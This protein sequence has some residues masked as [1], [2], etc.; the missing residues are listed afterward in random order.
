DVD[1]GNIIPDNV[2]TVNFIGEIVMSFLFLLCFGA[3]V[4][5][6]VGRIIRV[7]L[8]LRDCMRYGMGASFLFTGVDHF[9]NDT[10]RY[11]PMIPEALADHALA[12]VY[13]TGAAELAGAIALL[14]PVSAYRRLG[15][16]NL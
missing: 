11:V 16:P 14:I 6:A 12:W 10:V 9:V 4:A 15:L 7:R 8:T 13:L 2:S 3:A 1:S 5:W